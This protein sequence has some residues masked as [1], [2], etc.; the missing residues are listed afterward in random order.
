MK[1]LSTPHSP[2]SYKGGD[3]VSSQS[4]NAILAKARAMYGKCLKEADYQGLLNCKSVTEIAAYLKQRTAYSSAISGMNENEIHRGQLET[5]LRQELYFDLF[6]LSRYAHEDT[7]AFSDFVI[8]KM[9]IEQIIKCLMLV[10][11]GKPEE[12]VYS[13]PLSLDKFAKISLEALAGVR[14]YSDML[15]ALKGS[16]YY[17]VLL[18]FSPKD[19]E[20][21]N[22]TYIEIALENK[23]YEKAI[24]TIQNGKHKSDKKELLDIFSSMLDI[25]NMSR[26]IRLKKYYG[27][28]EEE[29]MPMLIPY[30]RLSQKMLSELCKAENV[31]KIFDILK[32]TYIGR[33]I[34]KLRYNEQN[35]M[36]DVMIYNYC[37][38][39][40]RLS[41]NPTIVM[42]SYIYLR[43][44][45]LKN[46]VNLIEAARYSLPADEKAKLLIK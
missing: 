18:Q 22:I 30:G 36:A 32:N 29:I 6:A 40:L 26:I 25:E 39:H 2:H 17:S 14:S 11:I 24:E 23:S 41:P 43:E 35:Q 42:I 15:D 31:D 4:A 16:P 33:L 34:S 8:S 9:E 37:C 20:R 27:F 46:I 44:I 19:N 7:L 3:F 12:Y 5:K 13:M 38:H 45:E 1:N 10:N 28:S 21:I